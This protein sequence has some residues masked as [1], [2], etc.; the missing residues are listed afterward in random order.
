MNVLSM[1]DFR[2]LKQDEIDGVTPCIITYNGEP[3]GIYAKPEEVVVVSDLHIVM[4]NRFKGM[5][6]KARMGMPP[7]LL[8]KISDIREARPPV[9]ED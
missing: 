1:A 4:R 6:Q 3:V 8:K 5:E 7:P 2:K 9:V